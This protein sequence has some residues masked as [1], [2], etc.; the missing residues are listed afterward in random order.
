LLFEKTDQEELHKAVNSERIFVIGEQHYAVTNLVYTG[1]KI[2]NIENIDLKTGVFTMDFYLWFKSQK[3]VDFEPAEIEFTNAVTPIHFVTESETVAENL[4]M[5]KGVLVPERDNDKAG[6]YRLYHIT[7]KD[8]KK[9]EGIPEMQ[10]GILIDERT[11]ENDVT[12]RLYRIKGEFETD[13]LPEHRRAGRYVLGTHFHHKTLTRKYLVYIADTEGMK[14]KDKGQKLTDYLK[15][16]EVL[17]TDSGWTIADTLFFQDTSSSELLS[18]I[19]YVDRSL[20]PYSRFN[21]VIR[22]KDYELTLRGVIATL[23]EKIETGNAWFLTSDYMFILTVIFFSLS[24]L[25]LYLEK[26]DGIKLYNLIWF[27]QTSCGIIALLA[28]QISIMQQFEKIPFLDRQYQEYIMVFFDIL[29]WFVPAV[30]LH[31]TL[32]NLVWRTFESK[33][34]R[35]VPKIAR[36]LA[37]ILVYLLASF[38]VIAF[39]FDQKLTGLLAT[40]ALVSMIIGLAIQMNI[41]NIFSGIAISIERPFRIGDWVKIGDQE[42]KVVDMTWRTTPPQT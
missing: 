36:L 8:E 5:E 34:E 38:G 31:S 23:S 40:S 9:N 27:F 13:F 3:N 18:D 29:W 7:E 22:I 17:D 30:F 12:S 37:A 16:E 6:N 10:E 39:V 11:D 20:E 19:R 15:D 41:S 26:I 14:P 35:N 32:E 42:G 4:K 28:L 24:V 1:M 21:A 33:A 25:L 2:N